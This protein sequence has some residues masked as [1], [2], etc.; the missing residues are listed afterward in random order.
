[1]SEQRDS[2]KGKG[3]IRPERSYVETTGQLEGK[4]IRPERSYRN[5]GTVR[6]EDDRTREIM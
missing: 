3:R 1:M 4:S 5:N 2:W 6:K